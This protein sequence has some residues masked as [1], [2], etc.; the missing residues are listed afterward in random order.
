MKARI[1]WEATLHEQP[2]RALDCIELVAVAE[3]EHAAIAGVVT[4]GKRRRLLPWASPANADRAPFGRSETRLNDAMQDIR[5]ELERDGFEVLE[6][7]ESTDA[8]LTNLPTIDGPFRPTFHVLAWRPEGVHVNV[9]YRNA[10]LHF[11]G[12]VVPEAHDI[13]VSFNPPKAGSERAIARELRAL[14]QGG[15][16]QRR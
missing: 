1:T 6:E 11:G 12:V 2:D 7:C 9:R 10:R 13:R 16:L 5:R 14:I 8:P 3:L 4:S 15:G